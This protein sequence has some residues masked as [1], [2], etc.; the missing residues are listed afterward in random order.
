VP[1]AAFALVD[2]GNPAEVLAFLRSNVG[3]GRS[4]ELRATMV[5]E[6]ITHGL[7]AARQTL[8][9]YCEVAQRLA[10]WLGFSSAVVRS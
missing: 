1:R 2:S 3:S 8:A 7:P 10:G 5:E 6:A 4:P 9:M